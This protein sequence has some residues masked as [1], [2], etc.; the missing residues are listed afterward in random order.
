MLAKIAIGARLLLGI[1]FLGFGVNGVLH[2]VPL[3]QGDGREALLIGGLAASGYFFPLLFWTYLLT[4]AALLTGRFVPLAL[5][6]LAP[7]IVN[8][9]CIHLFV[10]TTG[11]AF[12]L[13]VAALEVY[14]AWVYRPA[15]RT[16]LAVQSETAVRRARDSGIRE[17]SRSGS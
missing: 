1:V 15:F 12:A 17:F 6:V 13:L 10:S 3:P 11:L 5:T 7:I 4:G 2:L 16:L 14:L 8:V 9:V